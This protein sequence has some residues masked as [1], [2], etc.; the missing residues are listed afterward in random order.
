MYNTSQLVGQTYAKRAARLIDAFLP[1][2]GD[3]TISWDKV[4]KDGPLGNVQAS[5]F[6]RPTPPTV[7][8]H[9]L[10]ALQF[11]RIAPS[12]RRAAQAGRIVHLWWHPHNFGRHVDANIAQLR[13]LLEVYAACRERYGMRSM[14]MC[15]VA[16]YARAQVL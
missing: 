2:G 16:A 9:P 3:H 11:H 14:S 6:L 15:E 10:R 8:Q 5:F 1:V 4:W 13:R 7:W 12:I